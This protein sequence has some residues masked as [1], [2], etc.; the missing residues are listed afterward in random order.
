MSLRPFEDRD[1]DSCRRIVDVTWGFSQH[2]RPAEAADFAL[3][4]YVGDALAV[5]DRAWV[6]EDEEGVGGFIFGRCGVGPRFRTEYGGMRGTLRMGLGLLRLP[7]LGLGEKLAW[8]RAARAHAANRAAMPEADG[9]VTLFAV[10]PAARGRGYGRELMDAYLDQCRAAGT[11]RI[12][13]ETDQSSSY[14][15]YDHYGFERV[16]SFHSPLNERFHGQPYEAFVYQLE[17]DPRG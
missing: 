4:A 6:V 9:E 16:G 3:R 13:L 17:L 1:L 15:F 2:L 14:G 12:V 11:R 7:G 5:S 10:D 8:L